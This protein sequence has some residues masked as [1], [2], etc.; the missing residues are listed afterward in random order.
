MKEG[1][2]GTSSYYLH[3]FQPSIYP[4][5]TYPSRYTY[6]FNEKDGVKQDV[7][8]IKGNYLTVRGKPP[9]LPPKK[10]LLNEGLSGIML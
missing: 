6:Y 2:D 1:G 10:H 8:K 7:L 4:L 3:I 5:K 9:L